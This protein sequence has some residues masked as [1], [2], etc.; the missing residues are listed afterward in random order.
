MSTTNSTITARSKDF[1]DVDIG[2]RANPVTGDLSLKKGA[3]AIKQSVRNIL[4]T[5][6]GER[7][8]DPSF[9]SNIKSQ[10]FENFDPIVETL[11]REEITSSLSS[12]EPRV[13]ISNVRVSASADQNSMNI[14]IDFEIQSPERTADSLTFSV[15]RLR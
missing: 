8:F 2:F 10:L 9:G 1:A 5:N 4:L 7:P 6:R 12:Y 11:I 15:E 3:E 13:N 14:T